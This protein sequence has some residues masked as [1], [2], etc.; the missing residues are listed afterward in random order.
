MSIPS[1]GPLIN[2]EAIQPLPIAPEPKA[3]EPGPAAAPATTFSDLLRQAIETD[4]T[5]KEAAETYAAGTTQNLHETMIALEKA[6]ITL[7]L[8]VTVRNKVLEAY[9]TVM[10]MT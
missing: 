8:L 4:T 7:S 3:L 5:A 10:R 9:H 2:P 6:D 1:I